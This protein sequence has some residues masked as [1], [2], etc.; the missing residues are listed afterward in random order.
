MTVEIIYVSPLMSDD[1]MESMAGEYFDESHYNTIIDYDA[2]VYTDNGQLLAKFRRGVIKKELT[3]L[4]L[5]SF[6]TQARVKHNNRGASAGIL[7]V[8]KLEVPASRLFDQKKFRTKFIK[9]GDNKQRGT[10]SKTTIGN[11][12]PS[13]IAGFFDTP[14]RKDKK[15]LV[16][17]RMTQFTQKNFHGRWRESLPFLNR[18]DQL[19]QRLVPNRHRRQWL[20]ANMTPEFNIMDTAFSTITINYSWRTAAHRD[21]G[22]Y[23]KGFGNLIVVEDHQ[24]PNEYE[25]CYTGFP[26]YGVAFDV[27]TGDFLAM[28]VHQWHCN[29]EFINPSGEQSSEMV[30]SPRS[31]K[32]T[33]REWSYNRLSVV[34]YLRDNMVRC[35]DQEIEP[36]QAREWLRGRYAEKYGVPVVENT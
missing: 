24:N 7:D 26:Q 18:C 31:G 34:C 30:L 35:M 16:P 2:D 15:A 10:V 17:C 13:N 36:N 19:F 8:N 29:T 4:A 27:R 6:R 5:S 14:Q 32:K 33:L 21:A 12:A 23:F 22:D 3:E 11:L 9:K 28:D 1:E 25:G 20:K